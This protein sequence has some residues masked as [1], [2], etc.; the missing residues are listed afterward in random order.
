MLAGGALADESEITK[1]TTKE[2]AKSSQNSTKEANKKTNKF[3]IGVYGGAGIM[4]S[5][6]NYYDNN[7]RE[8]DLL[9]KDVDSV[10]VTF[11]GKLGYDIYLKPQHALRVYL[12][13]MGSSYGKQEY[14]GSVKLHH[15]SLN[16]DYHYDFDIGFS[17]FG[18]VG[19]VYSMGKTALGD[20]SK[21]DVGI[22]L[23]VGYALT[24]FLEVELKARMLMADYF[25]NK[26][27]TPNITN[28]PNGVNLSHA[29]FELEAPISI[30]LGLN[31]RF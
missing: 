26:L 8:I 10:G 13:Y 3:I 17:L 18:G 21:A 2:V 1:E 23:G 15:Y 5:S 11:G 25:H 6:T 27:I 19:A 7:L 9:E 22:N 28:L 31:F 24:D 12:D 4:S 29:S 16:V 30:L 20:I 14:V